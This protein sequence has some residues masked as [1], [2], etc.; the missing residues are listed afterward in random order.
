M[1]VSA[2]RLAVVYMCVPVAAISFAGVLPHA[3]GYVA[4]FMWGFVAGIEKERTK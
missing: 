2:K 3:I 4:C 1:T